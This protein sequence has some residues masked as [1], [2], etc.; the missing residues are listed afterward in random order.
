MTRLPP[1]DFKSVVREQAA[2]KV[3]NLA[4][5]EP[6]ATGRL[7]TLASLA[8]T[9]VRS[10][11]SETRPKEALTKPTPASSLAW[12]AQD[13]QAFFDERAGIR[14]FDGGL[15]RTEAEAGAFV[16]CIGQWRPLNPLCP[17]ESRT[18]IHCGR[19]GGDTPV[20]ASGGH[21]WLHRECWAPMNDQRQREA[22]DAVTRML[23]AS[24]NNADPLMA[25]VWG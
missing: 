4:N 13:W 8:G 1:F 17:S 11:V 24:K 10:A 14:E 15:S 20:L 21:A 16:D 22:L 5:T 6:R 25:E 12:T 19:E 7:A 3:A 9:S 2:A 23:N 18:C